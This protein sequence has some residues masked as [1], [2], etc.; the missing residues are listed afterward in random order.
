[1]TRGLLVDFTYLFSE[2]ILPVEEY[3]SGISRL[4]RLQC[5]SHLLGY[6][7]QVPAPTRNHISDMQQFFGAHNQRFADEVFDRAKVLQKQ[8]HSRL[9]F[10]HPKT[11]LQLYNYCFELPDD[12]DTKSEA[13]LEQSL[14]KA[15]LVLNG[16]Y[17]AEQD[18][19]SA[20]AKV[21]LP[22]QPLAAMTLALTFSD[23]EL[24]NLRLLHVAVLQLIKSVRLFEFLEAEARF[25][26]LLQGFLQRFGCRDWPEYFRRLSGVTKPVM[27]ANNPGRISVEIPDTQPDFETDRAFLRH[28]ALREGQILD[29]ADFTSLR[30]TPLVEETPGT[31]VLAYPVLVVEA[32]HKGLF[33]QFNSVNRSLPKSQRESDWRSVYCDLFSEQYLM[34]LLLDAIFQGRGLALSGRA[35]FEGWQLKGQSEPDYYFRHD[36]RAVLFESKD[37]WV[38]KVAKA[39]H[40]FATYLNEVK[41]KFYEDD[42]GH[43]KAA[44]QLANNVKRLL[45][46]KL[47]FDTSFD[48]AELIIYPVLVVHDRLY[49]QPGLNVVVNDWFQEELAKLEQQGLPVHNVRPLIIVD[50]DTLL[51][52]HEDF[53]DGRMVFEDVLEEYLAYLQAP[54]WT[55]ISEAED[56]QRQMQSIHPFALFLENY[57]E[58]RDMLGIPK[59]MLYQVLP[60]INRGAKD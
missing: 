25:A 1:M 45:C 54:A 48:P 13:E 9:S 35:I 37:V 14:F 24:V 7:S 27:Q 55:G 8:G 34:Y 49:N 59:E 46:Q 56:E 31:F 19:A 38:N 16:P 2:P 53:R 44:R 58:K 36:N 32:M 50:V 5:V 12:P 23:F 3:L 15:C 11:V 20:A 21:L 29:K 39:G 4:R 57:A 10:L 22:T 60:I 42:K 30:A 28:F 52:Y 17:I 40:D 47:P 26:P 51:A 18:Q 6:L 33:F 43:P 41:K